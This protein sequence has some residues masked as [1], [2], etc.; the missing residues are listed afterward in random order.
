LSVLYSPLTLQLFCSELKALKK[1]ARLIKL[2]SPLLGD[3]QG[4]DEAIIE[5]I[6]E[7]GVLF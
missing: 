1:R 2:Y 5:S 3:L 6:G 7:K 4:V